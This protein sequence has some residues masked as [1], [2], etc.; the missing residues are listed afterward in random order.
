MPKT[1]RAQQADF[2]SVGTAWKVNAAECW[3]PRMFYE[4]FGAPAFLRLL[5]ARNKSKW[6]AA[7]AKVNQEEAWILRGKTVNLKKAGLTKP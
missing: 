2:N 3:V 6:K 1:P 5:T 4:R 7:W